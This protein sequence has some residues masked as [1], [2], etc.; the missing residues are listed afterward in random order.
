MD[1]KN[2]QNFTWNNL[3]CLCLYR[4]F[5][6]QTPIQSSLWLQILSNSSQLYDSSSEMLR[7]ISNVHEKL[8]K[9]FSVFYH[10]LHIWYHEILTNL[11]IFRV[12]LLFIEFK[13]NSATRSWSCFVNKMFE[14]FFHFPVKA[15]H[16]TQ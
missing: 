13:S 1:L 7:S 9:T 5:W 16:W 2:Y 4:K 10:S 12:C 11:M 6:S 14:I 8:C 3:C 15:S